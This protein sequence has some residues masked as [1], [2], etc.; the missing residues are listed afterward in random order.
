MKSF[1]LAAAGFYKLDS[2][3]DGSDECIC[4]FCGKALGDWDAED[5]PFKE[6]KSHS[7][8]CQFINLGRR[9]SELKVGFIQLA[10]CQKKTFRLI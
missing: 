10:V 3:K 1:Q 4:F 7:T 2:A 6:H 8:N 5:D 9:E